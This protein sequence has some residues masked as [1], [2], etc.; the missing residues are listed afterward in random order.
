MIRTLEVYSSDLH[1]IA[2]SNKFH[3]LCNY[4]KDTIVSDEDICLFVTAN[5]Q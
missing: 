5:K 3:F 1:S 2:V 4:K